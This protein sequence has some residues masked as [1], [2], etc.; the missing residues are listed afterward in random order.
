M[1]SANGQTVLSET[2]KAV[3]SMISLQTGENPGWKQ[4]YSQYNYNHDAFVFAP[5]RDVVMDYYDHAD[6]CRCQN[7]RRRAARPV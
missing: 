5:E 1:M 2:G 4:F 7:A 3:P 6:V